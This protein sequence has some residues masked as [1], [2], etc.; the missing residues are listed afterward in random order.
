MSPISSKPAIG[1]RDPWRGPVVG[2]PFKTS[3]NLFE[4]EAS[5]RRT[6]SGQPSQALAEVP[7]RKRPVDAAQVPP[8]ARPF[9]LNEQCRDMA[10]HIGADLRPQSLQ[11]AT[12]EVIDDRAWF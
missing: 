1:Y 3:A 12:V 2:N 7:A 5:G 9:V 8:L 4:P 10:P 6:A 11:G